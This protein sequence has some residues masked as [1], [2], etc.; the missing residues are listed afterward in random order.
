MLR[1][2][3]DEKPW[4]WPVVLA[5]LTAVCHLAFGI[6]F[7]TSSPTNAPKTSLRTSGEEYLKGF[8]TWDTEHEADAAF[9]NRGAIETLQTG[10]PRTRSGLFFEHAPVYAYFLAACYKVGGINLL[11]MALPQSVLAALTSL[12]IGLS[13]V[14]LAEKNRALAGAAAAALVLVNFRVAGYVST[15]SPTTLLLCVF[16]FGVWG[17]VR[18]GNNRAPWLFVAAMSLCIYIQAAFF[19]MALGMAAWAVLAALWTKRSH[20]LAVAVVL[21]GFAFA[22]PLVSFTIDRT[23]E[24]HSTEPPSAVLWEA[25]NP[26]YESMTAFSLWER[27]PGN[28]WTKWQ[29]TP[30]QTARYD[31]Y[32]RRAGGNATKAALLW[33]RE[34]PSDYF[35]LCVVRFFAVVGPVTGQMSP[36]N[37]LL[38]TFAW[39][40]IVPVG[41]I[42]LW[43]LRRNG[44]AWLVIFVG[45]TQVAFETMVMAGWQPR[46]RLPIELLL[47]VAAGLVYARFLSRMLPGSRDER[48]GGGG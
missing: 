42:G 19:L 34:H 37:K 28:N 46:Y 3:N 44:F 38:S 22:K 14:R 7:W 27:R 41:L 35:E 39:A 31:D 13:A 40:L 16:A 23:K 25:N 43:K 1:Y 20:L 10:V 2:F 18:A 17:F 29:M 5:V 45:F 6:W 21:A 36:K 4:V 47:S 30:E 26:Y 11:A 9:Y 32:F 48:P 8:P 15:P 12:F 24:T 33:I